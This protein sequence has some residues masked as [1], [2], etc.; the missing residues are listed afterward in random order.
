MTYFHLDAGCKFTA[1]GEEF[2]VKQKMRLF[3]LNNW[4]RLK[5]VLVMGGV[6][7]GVSLAPIKVQ[8]QEIFTLSRELA[9]CKMNCGHFKVEDCQNKNERNVTSI[10]IT[11]AKRF[12]MSGRGLAEASTEF[13]PG[14]VTMVFEGK[15]GKIVEKEQVIPAKSSKTFSV[16]MPLTKVQNGTLTIYL[17]VSDWCTSLEKLKVLQE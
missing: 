8:A 17:R 11:N 5:Q 12:T 2:L 9:V 1:K 14:R 4:S 3:E 13:S 16:E 7:L 6:M 15:D 10:A